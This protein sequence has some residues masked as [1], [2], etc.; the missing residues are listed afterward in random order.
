MMYIDHW[1]GNERRIMTT[2]TRSGD[3]K[4]KMRKYFGVTHI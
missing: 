4:G 3:K 1:S 2:L